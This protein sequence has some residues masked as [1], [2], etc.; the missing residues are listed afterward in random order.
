MTRRI[1]I[2]IV[3][4]ALLGA[5]GGGSAETSGTCDWTAVASRKTC[6]EQSGPAAAI[7]DQRAGC[8][9]TSGTWG[10]S[11]CPVNAD[12]LGCCTYHFGLDFRECFY[13][14]R[15]PPRPTD[16]EFLCTSAPVNG[17]WTAP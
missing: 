15:V 14:G 13:D 3:A 5:C 10:S 16:P 9:S 6:L 17:A 1:G 11:P 7:A 8:E 12:L 2:G 4:A